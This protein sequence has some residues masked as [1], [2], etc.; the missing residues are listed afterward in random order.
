MN[1]VVYAKSAGAFVWCGD[2]FLI[3]LR[4]K[5]RRWGLPGGK[6]D[7][8]ESVLDAMVRELWEE[9][10]IVLRKAQLHQLRTHRMDLGSEGLWEFT[11][12]S[13]DLS[14][15]PDVTLNSEEH[16]EFMWVMPGSLLQFKVSG[17]S[18][19]LFPG[20][21]RVMRDD[22]YFRNFQPQLESGVKIWLAP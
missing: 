17:G 1:A 11:S 13:A 16:S 2:T 20:L 8:G 6:V 12:F 3:L 4:N 10:G 21:L 15:L 22:G 9:T 19:L 7:A 14:T 18:Q 5:D